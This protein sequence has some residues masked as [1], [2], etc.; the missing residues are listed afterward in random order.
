MKNLITLLCVFSASFMWSQTAVIES[1]SAQID[2]PWTWT[3]STKYVKFTPLDVFSVVPTFGLD[4]EV[5]MQRGSGLQVGIAAI[6]AAMQFLAA[7]GLNE[8]DRM[9]GYRFRLEGR[10]YMPVKTNRY[11]AAG[12]SFRHLIIKDVVAVGMEGVPGEFGQ[13]EFA[14]FQ[15]VPMRFNRFNTHF[16]LKYG[17]QRVIQNKIVIDCYMGFSL[18]TISVKTRSELPN[19][20][21]FTDQRG[22]WTLTD[23]HS[24][25][26]P[27]PILGFKFGFLAPSWLGGK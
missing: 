3:N 6:P 27:A 22:M 18:R 13:M 9:S 2:E 26:Y 20:G 8:Y 19:G 12:V 10:A 16:D 7:E 24:L 21:S 5:I 11:F 14:Y 25:T 23:N 4:Y 17:F 15:K 1:D